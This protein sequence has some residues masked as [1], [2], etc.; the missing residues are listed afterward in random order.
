M[1]RGRSIQ[2]T[3]DLPVGRGPLGTVSATVGTAALGHSGPPVGPGNCHQ[4]TKKEVKTLGF[5]G[6]NGIFFLKTF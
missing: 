2:L 6:I 5:D 4:S 3:S 1:G